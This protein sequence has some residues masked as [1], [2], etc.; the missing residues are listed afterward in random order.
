M[1]LSQDLANERLR[2]HSH[3]FMATQHPELGI[4]V[5]PTV[6]AVVGD[7]VGSPVALVKPKSS[8][9]LPRERHRAHAPRAPLAL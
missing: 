9:R 3:G 1:R 6:Y 5:G 7:H 8:T 4:D 2:G